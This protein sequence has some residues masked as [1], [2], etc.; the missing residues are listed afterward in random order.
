VGVCSVGDDYPVLLLRELSCVVGFREL[1][2]GLVQGVSGWGHQGGDAGQLVGHLGQ[3]VFGRFGFQLLGGG[4]K[5]G[6]GTDEVVTALVS[7]TPH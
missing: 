3:V 4:L 2:Q 6:G 7:L 1:D 5:S